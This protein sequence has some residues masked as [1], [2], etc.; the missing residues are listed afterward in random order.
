MENSS[1]PQQKISSIEASARFGITN[2]YVTLLCRRGQVGGEF[3]GR[4]WYV[5][6]KSL[7]HYLETSRRKKEL[8]RQTLSSQLK[9]EYVANA[10]R[11]S[12]A[13]SFPTTPTPIVVQ[14]R[15]VA[16]RSIA[17][18][19]G[20]VLLCA[21]IVFVATRPGPL[22]TLFHSAPKNLAASIEQV[23]VSFFRGHSTALSISDLDNVAS[24]FF[25]SFF[26]SVFGGHPSTPV[27]QNF[28]SSAFSPDQKA[29][30]SAASPQQ[31]IIQNIT[32][33][34]IGR[35]VQA[36]ARVTPGPAR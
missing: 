32:N 21:S 8:A 22:A 3:I 15:P 13:K 20:A 34:I 36:P 31:P 14:N 26:A 2:T 5:D 18:A 30:Q 17:F 6:E 12:D 1:Q 24:S 28:L 16:A 25:S 4:L 23:Q 35:I 7:E 19:V 27:A 9:R 29:S 10:A 11:P 33:P